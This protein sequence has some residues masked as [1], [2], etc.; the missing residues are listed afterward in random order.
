MPLE[1]T[2]FQLENVYKKFNV[3]FV[4][5][6]ATEIHPDDQHVIVEKRDGDHR[7]FRADYDY[8]LIATGPKLNFEG[9]P[10]LGPDN[11]FSHSICT[12]PHAETSR[13]TYLQE[14]ERMKRGEKRKFVIGTGHP[15]ATCQGAAFEYIT[16]IHK[17]LLRRGVRDQAELF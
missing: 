15:G 11:G 10:G 4:V 8:L 16:N 9:T 12:G 17:D 6:K 3:N 5:G 1:K 2:R 7:N 14:I 13:D